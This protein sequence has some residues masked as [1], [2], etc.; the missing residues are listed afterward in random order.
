[1]LLGEPEIAQRAAL[2][3]TRADVPL[4]RKLTTCDAFRERRDPLYEG[5][6]NLIMI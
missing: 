4:Q 2:A 1:M 5:F 3:L 6:A